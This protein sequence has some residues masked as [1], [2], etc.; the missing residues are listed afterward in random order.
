M[1]DAG[2][3]AGSRAGFTLI[4]MLA[5]V[6]ILVLMLAVAVPRLGV[7]GSGALYDQADRIQA[8]LELARQRAIVKGIP[9]RLVMDIEGAAYRVEWEVSDPEPS[10]PPV[11]GGRSRVELAAP[12][13][14]RT[15]FEPVPGQLG[16][17]STLPD[18]VFFGAIE[19]PDGVMDSGVVS[20]VFDR[21]GTAT[22]AFVTLENQLGQTVIL[23]VLPLADRIRVHD[24][25]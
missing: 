4:E 25:D 24:V 14:A 19:T 13:T 12:S 21:D 18:D 1:T 6:I 16:D 11:A 22:T 7:L 15:R 3:A 9:H 20:V 17:V 5:V 8:D 23:E 10:P 2:R